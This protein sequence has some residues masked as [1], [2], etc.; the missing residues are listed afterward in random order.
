[1]TSTSVGWAILDGQGG[2]AITLDHD[3][4]DVQSGAG[5]GDMSQH[6]AAA[7]G[8]HAIAAANGAMCP[9][10]SETTKSACLR[11]PSNS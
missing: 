5:L 4:F 2:D 11:A 9:K 8:A 7:R 10:S 6:A 1:M 3:A